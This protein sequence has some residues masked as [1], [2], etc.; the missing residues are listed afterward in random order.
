MNEN[1]KKE[2][3]PIP[4]YPPTESSNTIKT[5]R[6]E[7]ENRD[8]VFAVV[9]ALLG[10]LFINFLFFGG[11]GVGTAAVL[12]LM[13]A[14]TL[15]YRKK[16]KKFTV[17]SLFCALGT[18]VL[19]AGLVF[20]E[21][22]LSDFTVFTMAVLLFD[23]YFIDTCDL[24]QFRGGSTRSVLDW[25]MYFLVF[26]FDKL[27]D[28]GYALFHQKDA[29]NGGGRRKF[30]GILIGLLIA[31][32]LLCIVIPLLISSDAAFEG[33]INKLPDIKIG[34]I[35]V[36]LLFGLPMAFLLFTRQF[37]VNTATIEK[38]K[39]TE[40]RGIDPTVIYTVLTVV[41]LAYL[42]YLFS[43]L[44]YF[45]NGFSGLLPEGYNMAEYARRGFFEMCAVCGINLAVVFLSMF[46]CRKKEGKRPMGVRL[47]GLYLCI[48]SLF[49]D[50]TAMSKMV[51]YIERFGMTKL[52][53]VTSLFMIFLGV[54]FV[55]VILR[56]FIK[57]TP[58]VK[59]ALITAAIIVGVTAFTGI[60][61]VIADYNVNAYFEG[62]LSS[63]DTET[64]RELETYGT[65]P[66]LVR[67]AENDNS[68]LSKNAKSILND[69]YFS[70]FA[71]YNENG[72]R[73][74]NTDYDNLRGYKYHEYK[75]LEL[76]KE[77]KDLFFTMDNGLNGYR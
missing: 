42:L 9:M 41:S 68:Q 34:E 36:S 56:L 19:S 60:D 39:K 3:V 76:L 16:P 24:R 69:M 53:I 59:I 15:I 66:A 4:T 22:G 65:V 6:R 35:L 72:K 27:A 67:L 44:A 77:K 20:S 2:F 23:V 43:Q 38:S 45:V 12:I 52:R 13:F 46:L 75:G 1:E 48:F 62:K 55:A 74:F 18:L 37:A 54:T 17:Y 28:G 10:I 5:Q 25:A 21:K 30:L 33:L 47:L 57:K 70:A 8:L 50:C 63:V 32:P 11:Q 61:R 14:A 26:P 64:L 51:M 31:F 40:R 29:G 49:L 7:G 71:E 73:I 58:Y